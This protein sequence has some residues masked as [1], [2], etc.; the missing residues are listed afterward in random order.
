MT[1]EEAEHLHD[2]F[3]GFGEVS[4]RPMFG[5]HGVYRDGT[6]FALAIDGGLYL[7]V[8]AHSRARFEAAGCAPFVYRM[9]G[10]PLPL[11]YWSAPA[12]AVESAEAMRPWAELA[13]AAAAR[14]RAGGGRRRR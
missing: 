5:A 8:D 11:S 6:I 4:L 2:L 1:P 7:K 9:K 3:A 14:K 10:R 12:E 13:W